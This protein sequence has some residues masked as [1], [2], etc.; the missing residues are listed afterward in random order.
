M[1]DLE[2]L[3]LNLSE[4]KKISRGEPDTVMMFDLSDEECNHI[5]GNIDKSKYTIEYF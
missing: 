5:E 3:M 1:M 2:K 4:V